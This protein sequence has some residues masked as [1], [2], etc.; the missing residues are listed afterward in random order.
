MR[1]DQALFDLRDG[2]ACFR[3]MRVERRT[4][5]VGGRSFELAAMLAEHLLTHP[6][7]PRRAAIEIGVGLCLVS[8]GSAVAGCTVIATDRA[9]LLCCSD[10]LL[11]NDGL[12]VVAGPT[13]GVA[14]RCRKWPSLAAL[15]PDLV[16]RRPITALA[17]ASRADSSFSFVSWI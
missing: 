13:C 5:V 9:P 2:Q 8:V 17:K 16:A 10:A 7:L 1:K 3:G 14:D 4:L 11:E 6:G 12:A 15:T